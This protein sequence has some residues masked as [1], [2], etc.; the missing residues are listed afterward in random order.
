MLSAFAKLSS[1]ESF[2]LYI[3]SFQAVSFD[4][5]SLAARILIIAELLI[6]I[7]LASGQFYGFF[8]KITAAF[9]SAFSIFLLW[10]IIIGDTKSCHCMGELVDMNPMQ[11]LL[12]NVVM[13]LLLAYSWSDT[14][15]QFNFRNIAAALLAAGSS[16]AVFAV[17]PP[18]VYY[19]IGRTS[20][21]ISIEKLTPVTDSLGLSTGRRIICLY[22]ATCEHCRHSASKLAG[23][24]RRHDIPHDSVSVIFM[25]THENQDSVSREFFIN[26]GEGLELNNSYLHPYLFLP[27]TN[28]A[29]PLILLY[30]DG[31][32]VKEYDYLSLNEKEIS[33][34]MNRR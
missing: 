2:E 32:V 33:D 26:F 22:S 31:K 28:G 10:R 14:C 19:R 11:S 17:F 27:V 9:L 1:L 21:D 6:G 34:F 8:K 23:I 29:M 5:S 4:I 12:K 20:D 18:D 30:E 7:G 24:I 25:Q 3:F 15:R 16:I 13:A